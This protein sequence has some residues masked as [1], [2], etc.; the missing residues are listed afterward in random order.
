MTNLF[1]VCWGGTSQSWTSTYSPGSVYCGYNSNSLYVGKTPGQGWFNGAS[2]NDK[3]ANGVTPYAWQTQP[4]FPQIGNGI[5]SYLPFNAYFS[6][7][8]KL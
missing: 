4:Y 3:K 6:A 2:P 8:V 5:G 1:H 7:S